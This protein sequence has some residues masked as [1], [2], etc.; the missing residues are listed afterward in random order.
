MCDFN[1]N[2]GS[3][4]HFIENN[5]VFSGYVKNIDCINNSITY[6]TIQTN[7]PIKSTAKVLQRHLYHSYFEANQVIKTQK[8]NKIKNMCQDIKTIEDLIEFCIEKM[9]DIDTLELETQVVK[10]K[11]KELLKEDEGK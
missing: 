7:M 1:I 6:C 8:E 9:D 10:V 11:I 4:V 3:Y 2:I 5:T